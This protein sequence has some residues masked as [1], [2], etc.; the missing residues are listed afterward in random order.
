MHEPSFPLHLVMLAVCRNQRNWKSTRS[1]QR[2]SERTCIWASAHTF[3]SEWP[4][5]EF[6][7]WTLVTLSIDSKY[8]DARHWALLPTS[9]GA[10]NPVKPSDTLCCLYLGPYRLLTGRIR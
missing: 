1:A 10:F 7:E 5:G 8:W 3:V 6:K 4:N 2:C 9:L